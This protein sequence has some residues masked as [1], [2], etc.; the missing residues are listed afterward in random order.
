MREPDAIFDV[1]GTLIDNNYQHAL[2]WHRAFRESGYD[3]AAWRAHRAVGI[4]SEQFV[5]KLVDDSAEERSGDAIRARQSE[6][7]EEM[8]SEVVP[9]SGADDLIREL[10]DR[11][12]RVVL[13]SSGD[14]KD[15]ERFVELAGIED[16][17]HELVTSDEVDLAKPEPDVVEAALE[18][19]G[20]GPAVMVGDTPYD[21]EAAGRAEVPTIGVLSGGF[22]EDELREAGAAAVYASVAELL[23]ELGS[24]PLG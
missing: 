2:A 3:V 13:A 18:K 8:I 11:G 24:S 6:L 23:G 9:I 14:R 21:V 22:S 4:G 10:V 1:D 12:R 16:C 15:I 19:L 5:A 20:G 7:F 17:I